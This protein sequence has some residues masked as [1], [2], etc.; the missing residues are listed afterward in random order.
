MYILFLVYL[1]INAIIYVSLQK[2]LNV[3]QH[4]DDSHY[5]TRTVIVTLVAGLPLVIF[6]YIKFYISEIKK[7]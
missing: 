7:L 6:F 1:F 2:H 3:D 4:T 5:T